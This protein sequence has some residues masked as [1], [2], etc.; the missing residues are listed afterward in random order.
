MGLRKG[1]GKWGRGTWFEAVR[2]GEKREKWLNTPYQKYICVVVKLSMKVHLNLVTLPPISMA[3]IPQ[4]Y[5]SW[6]TTVK[7]ATTKNVIVLVQWI[8]WC[9]KA[10]SECVLNWTSVVWN[11]IYRWSRENGL[12]TGGSSR[13]DPVSAAYNLQYCV[14][15]NWVVLMNSC[16]WATCKRSEGGRGG[17]TT[18][19]HV[20]CMFTQRGTK[21]LY[22]LV[23]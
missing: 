21:A 20:Q 16:H 8:W 5:N 23:N 19:V 22:I 18:Y 13:E 15:S 9:S 17:G 2:H 14:I 10:S 7:E 6:W 3:R 1:R 4:R 11:Y 12:D